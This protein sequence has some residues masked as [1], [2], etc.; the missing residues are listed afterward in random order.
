V[1]RGPGGAGYSGEKGEAMSYPGD[2]NQRAMLVEINR[3]LKESK[4]R[5]DQA[6]NLGYTQ[7]LNMAAELGIHQDEAEDIAWS[8]CQDKYFR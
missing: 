5:G 7:V 1:Y 2:D 3:R 6:L 4:A 8:L